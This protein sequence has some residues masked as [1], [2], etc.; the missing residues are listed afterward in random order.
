LL[1]DELGEGLGA[2]LARQCG[3]THRWIPASASLEAA[4]TS[5][6]S[7]TRHRRCRCCLPALTGFTTNRRGETNAGHH[8]LSNRLAW[9]RQQR[10][11]RKTRAL[12]SESR[13][14]NL[15]Q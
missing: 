6:S 5:L 13:S 1:P 10:A 3:V 12:P 7:G 14:A 2:P 8:V 9:A 4:R 15:L 11:R